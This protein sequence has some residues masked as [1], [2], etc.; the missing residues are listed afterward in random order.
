MKWCFPPWRIEAIEY[1][2]FVDLVAP[3]LRGLRQEQRVRKIWEKAADSIGCQPN[4]AVEF[5]AGLLVDVLRKTKELLGQTDDLIK[6]ICQKFE[7]YEH[8]LSIPGFGPDVSSKVLG[9][10]GNP[11]RFWVSYAIWSR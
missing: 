3:R 8:L 4:E 6:G 10:I 2:E 1:E 5:E 7:E 9:A 11:F